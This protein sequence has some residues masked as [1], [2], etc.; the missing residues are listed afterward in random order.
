MSQVNSGETLRV[1][2]SKRK[3]PKIEDTTPNQGGAVT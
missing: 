3:A 1:K 2:R